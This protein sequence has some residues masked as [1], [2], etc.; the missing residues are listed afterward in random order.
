MSANG[1]SYFLEKTYGSNYEE[2]V[3]F[4]CNFSTPEFVNSFLPN[5]EI[6]SDVS[7]SPGCSV[8]SSPSG[9]GYFDGNSSVSFRYSSDFIDSPNPL[10]FFF[11]YEKD[12]SSTSS[13]SV[14]ISSL[15][16]G[17]PSQDLISGFSIGVN[18]ANKLFYEYYDPILRKNICYTSPKVLADKNAIWFLSV[19]NGFS[20]NWYNFG[21]DSVDSFF[22]FFQSHKPEPSDRFSIGNLNSNAPA[23][24]QSGN[25]KGWFDNFA[26]SDAF[27]DQGAF[28]SFASGS[29]Y[30]GYI[31]GDFIEFIDSIQVTGRTTGII[32]VFSGITGY[33]EI[34]TGMVMDDFGNE[35]MG[36][37]SSGLTGVEY[38][39]GFIDL[40]GLVQV[41]VFDNE[42]E[43]FL[44][45]S[46]MANSFGYF[47][48]NSIIAYDDND[49]YSLL[50]PKMGG[51]LSRKSEF[52]SMFGGYSSVNFN[53]VQKAFIRN[54]LNKNRIA[55]FL[56]GVFQDSGELTGS[57]YS[58]YEISSNDYAYS[59]GKFYSSGAYNENDLFSIFRFNENLSSFTLDNFSHVSGTGN[60]VL[61]FN[62]DFLFFFN[63]QKISNGVDFSGSGNNVVFLN[64][65]SLYDGETGKL[66]VLSGFSG[67][68]EKK[69]IGSPVFSSSGL[70]DQTHAFWL[71]G[72]LK[73]PLN[74]YIL[75]SRS[76]LLSGRSSAGRH[77]DL[78]FESELDFFEEF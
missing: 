14:L 31:T 66:S 57:K 46:G 51:F 24:A 12:Y 68:I 26:V 34:E 4:Y 74:D 1:F 65:Y 42:R 8:L 53:R 33:I 78:L 50:D 35:Y 48:V 10:S 30:S 77:K 76:D 32:P 56:N 37:I 7:Y 75:F 39:S 41:P 9:S 54:G 25:F 22:S 36:T 3:P 5:S 13:G 55:C 49:Q 60:K 52:S 40:T 59:G 63:G 47:G 62:P 20:F 6:I 11:I 43:I 15:S 61:N 58:P 73:N 19:E 27:L 70:F 18:S 69:S 28:V 2:L 38:A 44:L 29:I 71:N 67:F 21:S 17:D 16:S 45:D 64:N 23:W 72:V